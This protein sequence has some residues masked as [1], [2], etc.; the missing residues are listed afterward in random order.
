MIY[1]EAELTYVPVFYVLLQNKLEN[2]YIQALQQIVAKCGGHLNP[3]SFTCDFEKGLLNALE[4]QFPRSK[5]VLC[6]FHWKQAIRRKLEKLRISKQ[7][8]SKLVDE[9]G[10]LNLLTVIPVAE[11]EKKGY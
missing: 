11:I 7:V 9:N 4:M 3:A 5:P 1:A 10:L 2:T 8:I 6:L